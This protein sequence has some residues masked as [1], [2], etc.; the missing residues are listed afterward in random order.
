MRLSKVY[1]GVDSA[2]V[3]YV[4]FKYYAQFQD[5]APGSDG[6]WIFDGTSVF[7]PDVSGAG[8]QPAYRDE[9][10]DSY[11]YA[12]C[13]SSKI[14]VTMA[15]PESGVPMTFTLIPHT[16]SAAILA[17]TQVGLAENKYAKTTTCSVS[18][19]GKDLRSL[20]HYMTSHKMFGVRYPITSLIQTAGAGPTTTW[21]WGIR[22]N[23]WS[24]SSFSSNV[25]G[26]VEITYYVKY[27]NRYISG[28]D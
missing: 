15:N 19:G 2:D 16:S 8:A 18:G 24:S 10:Y 25:R 12:I 17:T 23:N 5:T 13:L 11:V 3:C 4:K 28:E 9:Y 7:D 22:Y 1:Q 26:A 21:V 27:F 14:K 6:V 20:K